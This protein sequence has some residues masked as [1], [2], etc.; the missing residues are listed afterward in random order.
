MSRT[1]SGKMRRIHCWNEEKEDWSRGQERERQGGKQKTRASLI[2]ALCV[3]SLCVCVCVC[4]CCSDRKSAVSRGFLKVLFS[5][6]VITSSNSTS[7]KSCPPRLFESNCKT[8][9]WI[10]S[11]TG[12]VFSNFS[13]L[14]V[15]PE[16]GNVKLRIHH[17]HDSTGLTQDTP[18]SLVKQSP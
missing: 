13:V 3:C 17:T 2:C 5:H 15:Q 11:L 14:F 4:V 8:R 7:S 16:D 1:K 18:L 6:T 12:H 9:D 10:P